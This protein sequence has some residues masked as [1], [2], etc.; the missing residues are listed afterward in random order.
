MEAEFQDSQLSAQAVCSE[1][2][3]Q[4]GQFYVYVLPKRGLVSVFLVFLISRL[5]SGP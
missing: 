3:F 2:G 5:W 1:R 4:V